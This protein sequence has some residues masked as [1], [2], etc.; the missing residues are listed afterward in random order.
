MIIAT[1][2]R[3][4]TITAT[5]V[6]LVGGAKMKISLQSIGTSSIGGLRIKTTEGQL[7]GPPGSDGAA[8]LP[9]DPLAYY[10]LAKG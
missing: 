4:G 10:I 8:E 6:M 3:I 7:R 9:T 2:S 1:A 5:G